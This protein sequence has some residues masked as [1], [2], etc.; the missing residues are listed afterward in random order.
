MNKKESY[1]LSKG[2]LSIL[3]H[4]FGVSEDSLV[5]DSDGN[6]VEVRE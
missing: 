6:V 1:R 2:Q 5:Q 3:A 4:V